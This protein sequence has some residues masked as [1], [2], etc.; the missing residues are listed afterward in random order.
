MEII[1][2]KIADK[3]ASELELDIDKRE[4]IAYGAFSLLQILTSIILV[5]FLGLGFHVAIE[6]LIITFVVAI[7]RKY[8]GGVHASNPNTCTLIGVVACL[9]QAVVIVYCLKP[10]VRLNLVIILG[11]LIFIWSYYLIFKVVPI[12]S[13]RKPIKSEFKKKKMKNKSAIVLSSYLIIE[14]FLIYI[15]L[16]TR[17]ERAVV[18]SLCIYAGVLWQGF[19]LTS[20][21]SVFV[22]KI[23]IFLNYILS[24][25]RR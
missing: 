10:T 22:A 13:I 19:T 4:V 5:I 17:W 21:G 12:D 8:S 25:L 2:N 7:L 11:V 6:S 20:I 9:V 1:A 18:Y 23:D 14:M 15:Y 24:I 16:N 3:V